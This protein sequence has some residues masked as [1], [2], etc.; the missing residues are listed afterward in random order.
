[1]SEEI[2]NKGI[3]KQ[4]NKII[5]TTDQQDLFINFI[6]NRVGI[7][8]K[9]DHKELIRTI[10]DQCT[11]KHITPA[12]YLDLLKQADDNSELL[13]N[14]VSAI[15]IGETY[16]FRDKRQI[17]LLTD[18]ILPKII[19]AKIAN[20]DKTLR[21]WSAGCSSG[22]EIYSIVMILKDLL[23]DF[24]DWQCYFLATDI[25][26]ELLRKAMSGT[27]TEWSMRSIPEYYLNK[28]FTKN[29]NLYQLTE[30]IKKC[31]KFDYL[32]L[33]T[34]SYPSLL[35]GTT[36]QDLILCRNVLIYFDN[37]HIKHILER[38]SKSIVDHG[39][40]L[41]GASDPIAMMDTSVKSV[42]N[43]PSLFMK[44]SHALHE[45]LP[46]IKA[47]TLPE[48]PI[49]KPPADNQVYKQ[50]ILDNTPDIQTLLQH[51]RW[52][53]VIF[54]VEQQSL[55]GN[56]N[57]QYLVAKATA[58]ANVG[59]TTEAMKTCEEAVLIDKMNK[60][61][62]FIYALTLSELNRYKE[63]ETAFRKALYIDPD[64]LLC[65]YQFGLFLI[66]IK[67]KQEGIKALQTAI[68]SA[69]RH[70]DNRIVPDSNNMSYGELV[71]VLKNEIELY[72]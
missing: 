70:E 22:E 6:H 48:E 47:S 46:D 39:F 66:R 10:Q 26:I 62:H 65:R 72:E 25:N 28:Y 8:I 9:R 7:L 4:K 21:I 11:N 20:N 38:L 13:G 42:Y 63:A 31:V 44:K 57:A 15:T 34:D 50:K 29:N 52:D 33:N 43:A 3:D 37:E 59:R 56:L 49:S 19:A 30:D 27:Y 68:Q 67:R 16:F 54:T 40:I 53:E 17:K 14:L 60:E 32:N 41:L 18:T 36:M 58:L 55:L 24:K 23:P 1:M 5:L 2:M 69:S 51:E 45:S 35:N 12:E 71:S 61:A 64:Y